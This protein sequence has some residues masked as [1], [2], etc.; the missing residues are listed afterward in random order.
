MY[1]QKF[2]DNVLHVLS[3]VQTVDMY[4]DGLHGDG[5]KYNWEYLL[6]LLADPRSVYNL[7]AIIG[8]CV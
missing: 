3:M 4:T 5:Y 6:Q 2:T 1:R 7:F 8:S